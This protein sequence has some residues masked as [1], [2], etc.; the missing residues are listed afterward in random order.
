[1]FDN[2]LSTFNE[3][4]LPLSK[5]HLHCL[6][7]CRALL[8][9]FV[10]RGGNRGEP[11][12]VQCVVF[13]A[14][15]RQRIAEHWNFIEACEAAL[16]ADFSNGFLLK[17]IESDTPVRSERKPS[18]NEKT[19]ALPYRTIGV[20]N[21]GEAGEGQFGDFDS[22]G[23]LGHLVVIVDQTLLDP[24]IGQ[25]WSDPH[26]IQFDVPYLSAPITDEF[27]RGDAWMIVEAGDTTVCYKA[28]PSM[29]AFVTSDSWTKVDFRDQLRNVGKAVAKLFKGKPKDELHQRRK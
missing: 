1:M 11:L 9:F 3:A 7:Y 12:A 13:G 21:P 18:V 8:D 28:H 4:M 6:P 16:L 14:D 5:G 20:A 19:I 23:W 17:E 25:I 10:Q 26:G 27:L 15:A 22:D 2:L 24:T 29:K